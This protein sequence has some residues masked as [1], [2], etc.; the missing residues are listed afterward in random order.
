MCVIE[1][2]PSISRTIFGIRT[3]D[4]RSLVSEADCG[5][6]L[7]VEAR[8]TDLLN[9]IRDRTVSGETAGGEAL[10][11]TKGAPAI[12]RGSFKPAGRCIKADKLLRCDDTSFVTLPDGI[13]PVFGTTCT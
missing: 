7:E 13:P 11:R 3:T 8:E 1:D 2:L 4:G 9:P 5:G 10:V 6:L 12:S